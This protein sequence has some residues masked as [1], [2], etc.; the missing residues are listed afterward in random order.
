MHGTD[1]ELGIRISKEDNILGG[2]L[3]FVCLFL[4]FF[5][6]FWPSH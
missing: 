3:E 5:D 2:V 6:V 4:N 1:L